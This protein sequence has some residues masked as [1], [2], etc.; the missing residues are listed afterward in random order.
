MKKVLFICTANICRS[1]MAV[2]IFDAL[3]GDMGLEVSAESAGVRA[4]TGEPAA[5]NT[6]QVIEEM[7]MDIG[8]HRAQQ[9]DADMLQRADLALTMTPHHRDLLRQEFGS[10]SE[11]IYTLPEYATNDATAGIADPYGHS[12]NAYRASSREILNYIEGTVKRLKQES[13]SETG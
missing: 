1:P 10:F 11:K 4:L 3:A 8:E 5:P 6:A 13:E 12:I 2:G 9:V 7:G